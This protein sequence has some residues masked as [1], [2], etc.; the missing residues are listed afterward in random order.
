MRG[1][2]VPFVKGD[3]R[4]G[5]PRGRRNKLPSGTIKGIFNWLAQE[6]PELYRNA[7]ERGLR[8]PE[9]KSFPCVQLAGAYLDGKPM[10]RI[11][12]T[13]ASQL[14]ISSMPDMGASDLIDSEPV[15][16]ALPDPSEAG[17]PQEPPE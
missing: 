10:E 11:A 13:G 2:G 7:I 8:A 14:F 4:A 6:E 1:P 3:K 15:L 16:A 9:A 17:E 5:R 12:I